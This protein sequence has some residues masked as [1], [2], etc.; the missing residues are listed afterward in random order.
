MSASAWTE[1]LKGGK[2]R[3]RWR[4]PDG[5]K[6]AT[7]TSPEFPGHPYSRKSDAKAAALDAWAKAWRRAAA[8]AGTL[9]P[10][11]TW[12]EWWDVIKE[13]RVTTDTSSDTIEL[14]TAERYLR[15]R[16]ETVALNDI[17]HRRIQ[18]WVD[19]WTA[20]TTAEWKCRPCRCRYRNGRTCNPKKG[21]PAAKTVHRGYALFRWSMKLAVDE[22]ILDP[23][24]P[25]AGIKLPKIMKKRRPHL[26]V[27]EAE[28]IGEEMRDDY[29][30]FMD[31]EH[32]TGLRPNE[33]AG[34]H[35]Y[36]I[37][38]R[39][40]RI[41]VSDVYVVR[42]KVI[43][44][45]P[46][47]KEPRYVPLTAKALEIVDRYLEGRDLKAGCGIQHSDN[48]KCAS[49]LVFLTKWGKPIHP[50]VYAK[51]MK[52][53]SIAAGLPARTP[54][55]A[56]RGAATRLADGGAD[57]FAIKD[58]MG[59]STMDLTDEYVQQTDERMAKLRAALGDKEPLQAVG[60]GGATVGQD[61]ANRLRNR[62]PDR[63]RRMAADQG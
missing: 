20:G 55:S 26:A 42:K 34:L 19:E 38:R 24:S 43:R 28:L 1:P 36:S 37:D 25:C 27:D 53:A 2:H 35:A 41:D 3:G 51:H 9:P 48:S 29:R 10:T 32:E 14:N 63:E 30:D 31:F 49:A 6:G 57:P 45:W 4:K 58:F 11:I 21:K 40:R 46:K 16:W 23:P 50:E 17:K 22:E 7:K 13:R 8:T 5:S 59:H 54:Y 33:L 56:R 39:R 44:A 12:G 62:T 47:D 15:P 18:T 52:N 61:R 60:H